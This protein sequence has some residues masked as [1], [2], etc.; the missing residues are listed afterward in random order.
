VCQEYGGL[1]DQFRAIRDYL[2]EFINEKGPL[3]HPSE[4]GK[5]HD[6][7]TI[8]VNIALYIRRF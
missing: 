1:F 2:K 4:I 6:L 3:P 8:N 5:I 7:E